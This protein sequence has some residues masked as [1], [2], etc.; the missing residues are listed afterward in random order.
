[1]KKIVDPSDL[2]ERHDW[3]ERVTYLI[4][5]CFNCTMLFL[6]CIILTKFS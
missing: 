2:R 5:N 3:K 4:T 1:M 6:K